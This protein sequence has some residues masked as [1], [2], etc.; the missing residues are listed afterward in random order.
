MAE[1]ELPREYNRANGMSQPVRVLGEHL[2]DGRN[3]V[4][5]ATATQSGGVSPP[6]IEPG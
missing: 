5:A 2:L 3:R 1:R 6:S 4:L